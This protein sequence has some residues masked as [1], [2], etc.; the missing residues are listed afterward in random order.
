MKTPAT[1]RRSVSP[2]HGESCVEKRG[3]PK[4]TGI[5]AV[6]CISTALA[7]VS[8][9]S[10]LSAS[11]IRSDRRVQSD[12][13]GRWVVD[14][15]LFGIDS[16]VVPGTG[17]QAISLEFSPGMRGDRLLGTLESIPARAVSPAALGF[18]VSGQ[19]MANF[20][21]V[22]GTVSIDLS[23][24]TPQADPSTVSVE[25]M[26]V[27]DGRDE[28][29][30]AEAVTLRD[31]SV[32][33]VGSAVAP[34]SF[35]TYFPA[36]LDRVIVRLDEGDVDRSTAQAVID[37]AGFVARRWSAARVVVTEGEVA[38]S[39]F[40]RVIEFRS[41]RKRTVS[42]EQSAAGATLVLRGP[43]DG[44]PEQVSFVASPQFAASFQSASDSKPVATDPV[45]L[46]PFV[47]V[48]D[49]R[50]GSVRATRPGTASVALDVP[51]AILGGQMSSITASVNGVA[52]SDGAGLVTVQLRANDRILET[53]RVRNDEAFTLTGSLAAPSLKSENTFEVRATGSEDS[54]SGDGGADIAVSAT[55]ARGFAQPD[56]TLE[57]DPTSSFEGT[58]G[59]GVLAGFER[60]PQAFAG[61]FN[62]QFAS[63]NTAQLSSA[64]ALI[65][66]LQHGTAATLRGNVVVGSI[67]SFEQL[68]RPTVYLSDVGFPAGSTTSALASVVA[69]TGKG[70]TV[71]GAVETKHLDHL[72]LGANGDEPTSTMLATVAEARTG[73]RSLRGDLLIE[74]GGVL[75]NLRVQ[76]DSVRV[77]AAVAALNTNRVEFPFWVG[78]LGGSVVALIVVVTRHRK[79]RA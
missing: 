19:P 40:D 49:L 43:A 18:A 73:F 62:L 35:A 13:P 67:P 14:G 16:L 9:P 78:Y 44:R 76:N 52:K 65:E 28:C 55:C 47:S 2:G 41:A 24:P 59:D 33:S 54:P 34:T 8:A 63:L 79:R 66:L 22:A 77:N 3:K 56:V 58:G 42:L 23:S 1:P 57:I 39:P 74:N 38:I 69:E 48:S 29:R 37:L 27:N 6:V 61:G 31:V 60:F 68:T 26:L 51:Q 72:V 32:L 70:T 20:P 4:L 12:G 71:L 45:E 50:G 11:T 17:T 75:K 36:V 21:Y 5:L 15:S 30:S 46:R 53:K 25:A 10:P 7:V 64:V